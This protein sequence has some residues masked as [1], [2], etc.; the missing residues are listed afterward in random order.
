M[1]TIKEVSMRAKV[2]PSTVSR[3][4]NGTT[5]VSAPVRRRVLAAVQELDYTPNAFARGLA[6]NRSGGVGITVNHIGSP[7]YGVILGGVEEAVE[8]AGMHLMVASGKAHADKERDAIQFMRQRRSDAL[9]VQAEALADEELIDLV[10]SS[11]APIVIFGRYVPELHD[12]CVHLDNELGGRIATEHLIAHGHR[13]IGHVAGPL[14]FPDSRHRLQGYRQALHAAGLP[15]DERLVVEGDFREEGGYAAAR[16]LLERV[17]NL[18]AIFVAN[19][20][21]AA[22]AIR[23]AGDL[24]HAVPTDLSL[25]GFDDVLL[26]QYVSPALTTVRQPLRDMGRAAADIAIARLLGRKGEVRTRFEP[27][28][29]LR[30]SV[31]RAAR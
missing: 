12:R 19:D 23:A 9:I 15:F 16:R 28:L 13:T 4:L 22:G 26:A 14:S 11:E 25:V 27:E 6:T 17:P 10:G 29:V 1:P 21:M 2:S 5:P 31:A 20:Q 18:H 30:Q 3:V 8:A 7:Y 24:G